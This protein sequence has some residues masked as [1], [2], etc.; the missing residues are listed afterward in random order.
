MRAA[1]VLLTLCIPSWLGCS[2]ASNDRNDGSAVTSAGSGGQAPGG[3]AGTGETAP[4]PAETGAHVIS[5]VPPYRKDEAQL[6][7]QADFGGLAAKDGLSYL[8]LQFWITDGP[9]TRLDNSTESD[10]VW[11]RDW[12]HQRGVRVLLCLHNNV[13]AGG[14][15]WPEA[16]RSYR[17]NKDAMVTHLLAQITRLELDGIDLDLEGIVDATPEEVDAYYAFAQALADGLHPEGKVVTIA[18]FHGMWNA[19]N[20]NWWPTL[21]TFVDGI[22][23]MGYEQSG[24]DVDYPTLVQQAAVAPEKLMI[25]VPSHEAEWLGHSATEHLDWI[26]N[27]GQVGVAIWDAALRDDAWRQ[28]DVWE[29]LVTV[30]NR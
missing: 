9:A 21:L 25:G 14:W 5:W 15:N 22:T 20:W 10:I 29:R 1:Y 13:D 19:P 12:G 11:F 7:L 8:A 16:V 17:D 28:A 30:K 24:L 6:A 26:V 4:L 18:S 3:A 23:S 27:Q 2:G